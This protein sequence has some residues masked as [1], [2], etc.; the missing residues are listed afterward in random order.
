MF[1]ENATRLQV[2]NGTKQLNKGGLCDGISTSVML[3][4]R[5]PNIF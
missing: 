4:N 2:A 5:D 3:L 1:F